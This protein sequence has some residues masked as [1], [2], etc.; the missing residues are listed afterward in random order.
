MIRR[1]VAASALALSLLVPSMA[2]AK[3]V[4][5]EGVGAAPAAVETEAESVGEFLVE[6]SIQIPKGYAPFP[7]ASEKLP[8]GGKVRVAPGYTV[9]IK[10]G[11]KTYVRSTTSDR[12]GDILKELN[13]QL[14]EKDTVTPPLDSRIGDGEVLRI[15]RRVQRRITSPKTVPYETVKRE[16]PEM[17][18]GEERVVQEGVNGI[19]EEDRLVTFVNDEEIDSIVTGS[20]V[21]RE[22][23]EKIVEVGTKQPENMIHGKKYTKKIVMQG[24]AYDP[25]AGKWTASGTPARVGAV[26]VDPRV[27]PLGTKLY[28]ESAD[29]FPTYG[30]AVAEDTGGAIKGNRIDLFYNTRGEA[31]Q[32]GRRNVVVYVLEDK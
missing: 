31:Y 32:F 30:F 20:R 12:V 16:N 9:T 29:G 10:D 3:T 2:E 27:V 6:Q 15:N 22:A 25:S 1:T 8:E 28:I 17:N 11:D 24:T 19:V 7:S 18:R 26:A 4:S 5:Y 13:I 21:I 14:G 23:R